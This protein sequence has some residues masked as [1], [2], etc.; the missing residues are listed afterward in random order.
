MF[1]GNFINDVYPSTID[2]TGGGLYTNIMFDPLK[3]NYVS[4]GFEN[5]VQGNVARDD[6]NVLEFKTSDINSYINIRDYRGLI[7]N[8]ILIPNPSGSNE[9]AELNL[10]KYYS[11]LSAYDTMVTTLTNRIDELTTKLANAEQ[12]ITQAAQTIGTLQSTIDAHSRK[13]SELDTLTHRMSMEIEYQHNTDLTH[14]TMI[15]DLQAET[16]SINT[17]IDNVVTKTD[18]LTTKTDSMTQV[19]TTLKSNNVIRSWVT[20]QT[21]DTGG[22]MRISMS[23]IPDIV[24]GTTGNNSVISIVPSDFYMEGSSTAICCWSD[25]SN[26]GSIN[27]RLTWPNGDG[28]GDNKRLRVWYWAINPANSIPIS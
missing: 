23:S 18:T 3:R 2:L 7:T 11:I 6:S 26:E 16:R 8:S 19:V 4:T 5:F 21:T 28:A 10:A 25:Y 20:T 13:L 27:V 12:T 15:S 22:F 24:G 9:L 1:T 17:R 14:G